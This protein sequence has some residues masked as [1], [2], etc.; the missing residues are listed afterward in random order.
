MINKEN[1]IH[2]IHA[3]DRFRNHL[4]VYLVTNALFWL[5]FLITESGYLY[6]YGRVRI[7]IWPIWPT[8]LWGLGVAYHWSKINK[9]SNVIPRKSHTEK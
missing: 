8:L 4:C 6:Y 2:L 9:L 1:L 7:M 5:L 3:R